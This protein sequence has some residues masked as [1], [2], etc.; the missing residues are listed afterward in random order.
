VYRF[1]R[2]PK[3]IL[4]HVLVLLLVVVMV[5][6][7]FWQLRRLHTRRE[8]N[9]SVR[10]NQA[11]PI[12]DIDQVLSPTA[13]YSAAKPIAYRRVK[14]TGAYDPSQE[15]LVRARSLDEEPG[16]WVLTPLKT[17]TGA[18]VVVSRGWVP[19]SGPIDHTPAGADP[20]TGEVTV[21]GMLIPT[22]TRGILGSKD[23]ATGHLDT[24]ARADIAR[25][26]QQV[27]YDLYPGFVQLA[28]QDPRQASGFPKPVPPPTL[29]EGP[30]LSYAVQWF[31]FSAIAVLGYPLILRR[32]AR[33]EADARRA[34]ASEGGRSDGDSDAASASEASLVA[35]DESVSS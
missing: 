28:T 8:F 20:P 14:V 16:V 6:L 12:V 11:A 27:P 26:Q 35:D 10:H 15:V 17:D 21:T 22:Q 31:T 5:N 18:A 23:P 7:G 25:L 30:H 33:S 3:W 9:S 2:R 34:Q 19:A 24:L 1:A 4:S 29:D 32:A 13:P